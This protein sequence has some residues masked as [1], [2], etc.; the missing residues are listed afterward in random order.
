V[1]RE[2]ARSE[3][4]GPVRAHVFNLLSL[5]VEREPVRIAAQAFDTSDAYL[6]GTALEYLETVPP[7]D[8]F[9]AL[10]T[11]LSAA[12]APILHKR[13]TTAARAELLHAA[14]T[15]HLSRDDLRR[16]LSQLDP[17]TER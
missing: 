17:D 4:D 5:A 8:I 10:A 15:M 12:V 11:R 9:T 16:E 13:N 7:P 6:R 2:L 3:E 14:A 1:A